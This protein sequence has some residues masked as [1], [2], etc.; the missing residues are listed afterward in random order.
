M[1]DN[2]T[3]PLQAVLHG[4]DART[5][6]TMV[7]YF[8]GPCKGAVVVVEDV[9]AEVDIVDADFATGQ[10]ALIKIKERALLRP[11]IVLSREDAKWEDVIY[12]EKPIRLSVILAA[13]EQAKSIIEAKGL[14]KPLPVVVETEKTADP[15][16][17]EEA[18]S[19]KQ[20]LDSDE[21]K[22]TAKHKTAMQLDESGFSTFIGIVPGIDF[23][24]KEQV[25]TA[26]Y[27]PKNYFQ[28]YV[29]SALKVSKEKNRMLQLNSN[30]KPLLIFPHSH[31]VWLDADDKQLRAF[32][33]LE[34]NK[35]TGTKLTI[36]AVDSTTSGVGEKLDR[37]HDMD[38]FIWKLAIWTSKGR[39]PKAIDINRPVF[40]KHWPNFTRSLIT[41][42]A[43]RITA[44]LIES[45]RSMLNI[46]EVL[47][48]KP[49]FVFVF[50]SAAYALG[51]VGQAERKSDE[52]FV[53]PPIVTP[54]KKESK[55]LLSKILGKLRTSQ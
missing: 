15:A 44:L 50:V 4:M 37:F 30:W 27:S 14:T 12:V 21:R 26:S 45:P 34:M 41:P 29:A 17:E 25:L 10:E 16:K 51:L 2:Q 53:P 7:M 48:V 31:E 9:D 28:G 3:K 36:T 33:S 20:R 23:N 24:D 52:L 6:K 8:Q 49:Q 13:F 11:V 46:S 35:A 22:K 19:E 32:A 5:Y 18:V 42:H 54:V 39:Y 55:G 43:L 40:I 1:K 38:A 47:N